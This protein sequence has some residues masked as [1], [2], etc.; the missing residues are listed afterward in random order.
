MQTDQLLQTLNFIKPMSGKL[1]DRLNESLR[2]EVLPR[3]YVLQRQG[4]TC[5]RIYFMVR[6]LARAFYTSDRDKECTVWFMREN[7]VMISVFSFFTQQ[8]ASET[9]ELLEECELQ[10]ITWAQLQGIYADFPEF[11]F[12][13]RIITEKYYMES[14]QRAILLRNGTVIDRYNLLLKMHPDIVRRVPLWMIASHLN[15]STEAL[16][17]IRAQQYSANSLK[18]Q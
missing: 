9:V 4:D 12:H 14:E 10:S 11:N 5:R 6:G 18:N 2:E 7:D 8:P 1:Q 3:K 17:R 16:C 13:G 15:V